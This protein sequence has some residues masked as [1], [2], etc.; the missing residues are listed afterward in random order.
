MDVAQLFDDAPGEWAGTY[1]LW[2]H[3]TDTPDAQSDSRATVTR[4]VRGRSLL[5]R[6]GWRFDS[7]EHEGLAIV[8]RTEEDGLQMGFSDSFHSAAGVMHGEALGAGATV[9]AHYGPE[10]APWGWR[11]EFEMPSADQL[12]VRAF[13]IRPDGTETLATEAVYRRAGS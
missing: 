11:T 5:V 9:I 3:S 6:Y 8:T 1:R 4:E 13:N 2:M 10:D 7:D 12:E